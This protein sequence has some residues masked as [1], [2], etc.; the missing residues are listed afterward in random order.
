MCIGFFWGAG[1]G[2]GCLKFSA[3]MPGKSGNQQ[4]RSPEA[5]RPKLKPLLKHLTN[6][7]PKARQAAFD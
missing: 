4:I 2:V 1:G 5:D 6:C 7:R 3:P